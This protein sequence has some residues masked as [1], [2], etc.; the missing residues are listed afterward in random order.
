MPRYV[1]LL[2]GINVGGH[3]KVPMARLR[4]VLGEAGFDEV[5]TYLQS[6][7]AVV[8]APEADPQAVA[9]RIEEAIAGAFGFEVDVLVRSGEELTAV[10]AANPFAEQAAADPTRV[11]ASFL[12]DQLDPTT[13]DELETGRF[14][15]EEVVAG[16][17][18]LYLHLPDGIGRSK[19]AAALTDR[20]LGTLATARNWRT[21]EA[22]ADLLA[23]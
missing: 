6:G 1:A 3:R 20:R 4:E 21:V 23:P 18:V 9:G 17:R 13:L 8:T 15:P 7:N 14:A 16:D 5:A 12:A 22:L 19:L 11:H 10:I 2:R